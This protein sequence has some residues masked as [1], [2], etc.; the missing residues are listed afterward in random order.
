M[1]YAHIPEH[2]MVFAG[3]GDFV[4]GAG[5]QLCICLG[6][7]NPRNKPEA[8]PLPSLADRILPHKMVASYSSYTM[9]VL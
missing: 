5:A 9:N 6:V 3:Q 2:Y 4:P 7:L 1:S 8:H